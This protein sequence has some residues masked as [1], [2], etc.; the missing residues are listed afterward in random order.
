MPWTTAVIVFGSWF[1]ILILTL[2]YFFSWSKRVNH[3]DGESG[4]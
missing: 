1:V 4:S 3:E 2:L